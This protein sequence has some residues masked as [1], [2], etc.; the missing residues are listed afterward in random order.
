MLPALK[1]ETPPNPES[2]SKLINLV[3]Q[4]GPAHKNTPL[5]KGALFLPR[6]GGESAVDKTVR[7]Y[8]VSCRQ[9]LESDIERYQS[10]ADKVLK[11]LGQWLKTPSV[12][13]MES[14][15]A[16]SVYA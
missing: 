12:G 13:G 10:M 3:E 7:F 11:D 16:S 2:S 8:N 4:S 15:L 1:A 14:H 6:T 9:V 5:G